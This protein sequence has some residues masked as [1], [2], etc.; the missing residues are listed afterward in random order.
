[1]KKLIG[2][3][4]AVI[5]IAA[6]VFGS[7]GIKKGDVKVSTVKNNPAKGL[8]LLNANTNLKVEW[9]EQ[10]TIP[11]AVMGKLT[12]PGF[13]KKNSLKE[14]VLRFLTS[15][16]ELFGIQNPT[17][18]LELLGNFEDELGQTHIKFQQ[19]YANIKIFK[20][21]MIVH[22]SSDGSI[23]GVNGKYYPTLIFNAKPN[24]STAQAITTAKNYL[25]SYS[26]TK[27]KLN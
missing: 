25:G 17:D 10:F 7:S 13:V 15:N 12:E 1:M 11:S 6:A 4:V 20:G 5:F 24:I 19:R 16:K 2:T 26:S 14:D 21:Q 23:I 8:S 18:E 3:V 22:V 27:E 9:N